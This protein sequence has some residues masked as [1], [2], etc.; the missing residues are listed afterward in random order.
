MLILNKL[1]IFL[2]RRRVAREATFH[3]NLGPWD[4]LSCEWDDVFGKVVVIETI[5]DACGYSVG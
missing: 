5:L 2:E 1:W 4:G 3:L